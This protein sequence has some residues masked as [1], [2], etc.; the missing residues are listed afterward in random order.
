LPERSFSADFE[1]RGSAQ[2][3]ELLISGP[4]GATAARA[5]WAPGM[6]RLDGPQGEVVAAD[7][8]TLAER[9]LGAALPIGALFDWLN[10]RPWP[11]APA[12]ALPDGASGFDQ[13][14]WRINLARWAERRVEVMRL[15]PP[16]VTVRLRLNDG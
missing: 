10:G 7:L 5:Q 9:A 8:S 3:G 2:A 14:G 11:E 6:A 12:S 15:A 13:L 4:F 16:V 1:L